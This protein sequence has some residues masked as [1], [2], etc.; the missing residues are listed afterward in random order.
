M[1]RHVV[2]LLLL[3][4]LAVD[5]YAAVPID[6]GTASSFGLL[7][8]SGVTNTGASVIN[9]DVG[10]APTPAVTGFPPGVVNGTLYTAAN[11]VT[12]Q[13][14]SDLT[15]AY[16]A[17]AGAAPT[18]TLTGT[19]LGF[20]NAGNPLS[21]GVYF[22]SSSAFLTG[23]LTL[24]GGGDPDAQWIFQIG[25]TL[26]TAPNS[27]VEFINGATKCN[28]FWQVGSS[29]TIDT[30]NVFAGNIMALTDITLNGGTLNGRALARN[31]AVTISSAETVNTAPCDVPEYSSVALAT[32][33]LPAVA[34][35]RRR[36]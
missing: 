11:A 22:F 36:K 20:Y 7:A 6:L 23:N 34:W 15:V 17:A 3:S 26:I 25:S 30:N 13:A 14:Q 27:S 5:A 12:A 1:K 21:A 35:F 31:G 28:V 32:M 9:G 4:L 2:L 16:N 29:A 10:S 24:D 8:G 18:A 33:V 19:D